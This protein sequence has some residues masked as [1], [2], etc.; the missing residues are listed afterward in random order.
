MLAITHTA[1]SPTPTTWNR[2]TLPV[3]TTRQDGVALGQLRIGGGIE[4]AQA[5]ARGLAQRFM[6]AS[7]AMNTPG[8]NSGLKAPGRLYRLRD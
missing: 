5:F 3:C 4:L 8:E 7:S 1:V 6:L 2:P